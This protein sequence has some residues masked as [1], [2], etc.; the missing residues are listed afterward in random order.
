MFVNFQRYYYDISW[1]WL[2]LL[3]CL[4]EK[5]KR[6]GEGDWEGDGEGDGEGG[7]EG[8]GNYWSWYI[9]QLMYIFKYMWNFKLHIEI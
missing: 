2:I 6:D 1:Q 9:I 8:G 5:N 4:N 3:K 7:G